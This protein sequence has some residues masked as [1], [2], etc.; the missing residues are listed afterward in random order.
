[1]KQHGF[2]NLN[3]HS[4][5]QPLVIGDE[6]KSIN[7]SE[8]LYNDG[9]FIPAIRYPT[10]EKGQSRLRI[11]LSSEHEKHHIDHLFKNLKF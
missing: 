8:S 4:H 6:R 9:I 11:S 3:S 5:V 2:N 10:V 7:L 1:M